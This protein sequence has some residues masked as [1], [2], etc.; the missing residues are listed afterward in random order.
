MDAGCSEAFSSLGSFPLFLELGARAVCSLENASPYD[1]VSAKSFFS[2]F[3]ILSHYGKSRL[4]RKLKSTF[5][6]CLDLF[7]YFST[8]S[9]REISL[10]TNLCQKSDSFQF[11]YFWMFSVFSLLETKIKLMTKT[12]NH[13]CIL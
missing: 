13:R 2:F 6:G 8:I 9:K 12:R 3:Y 5:V 4:G 7:V 1:A 10:E 11:N